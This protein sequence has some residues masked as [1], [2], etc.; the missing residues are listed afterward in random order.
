MNFDLEHE[1]ILLLL[2]AIIILPNKQEGLRG[3]HHACYNHL[4]KVT[5]YT[6]FGMYLPVLG[7]DQCTLY[8]VINFVPVLSVVQVQFKVHTE[9]LP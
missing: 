5:G 8:L 6:Q 9:C 4:G 7:H 3:F 1:I 2:T